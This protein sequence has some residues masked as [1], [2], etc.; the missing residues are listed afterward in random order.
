M[1]KLLLLLATFAMLL[2]T[3][4][5][6][7]VWEEPNDTTFIYALAGP[8]VTVSGIVRTCADSASGFFNATAAV[9]GIDS[10]IALTS[11]TLLN[12]LGP[13][14]NGGTTAMNSFDGDADLDELI[15]GY[16]TYDACFIEFDMTVM[17]D[18]V[19]I[20]YVF[21][22]EEYL[23]WVGSSFNDVFAFWVSGPGIT[24]TVNIATIPG[25]DIP[26]AINNVNSTSYPE[27]YVENG[28]GYT[29]PYASDPSYVQYD[30]LTTV[31]TGEIAVTAGETYHMKIAVADAGDYILD[32]GVFLETGSLGSLRIG[33]G[34]YGD[35]DALV[36]AEDCSNGYIEFT[37]YV[38][39]DLDLVIDYHIE[40]TAEMGVDYEVIASQI[41]IPAGMSTATLPIVPISD[42]LTEGDETV[43]LKL[44][45]PQSGY[46]YSEVE[47]ILADALKADFIAAGADGTFDF[48]DMSDSATEWFWDF[49]D[50]NN[51]TEA[52]PT[53][54][55]ATSGSYEVCLTITNENNCTATECRQIS[56]STALDGS[57]EEESIRL[58]PNPAH[59]Y[60]TIETGTTAASMVTLINITGQ[61]VSNWQVNGA[62]TTIPLTDIPS[63]SYILQITNEAGNH[64]LPLE[65]R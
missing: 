17:A 56:V 44:Y 36:A 23:E 45:N 8:G 48:V 61:V 41:T 30:G 5:Q 54:T 35:G 15:P 43:L 60:V 47:V 32:S 10:G 39:S 22:S 24:D 26:V 13:N 59:D 63:G 12:T 1:K 18:T 7:E 40:G 28:D 34:Y 21:G 16:F 27:F 2:P 11:G 29:E 37:N 20:S 64:Q 65:V 55:F 51:S 52:N 58:F 50:G 49:G 14:A 4:A 53:H 6:M 33:T 3:R 57:I 9:L 42:M 19:R 25:T 46:V 31:L 38:P 62:M